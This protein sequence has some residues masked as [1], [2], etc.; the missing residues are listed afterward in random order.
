MIVLSSDQW[1]AVFMTVL[2]ISVIVIA[3]RRK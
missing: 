3:L 2:Y 1:L